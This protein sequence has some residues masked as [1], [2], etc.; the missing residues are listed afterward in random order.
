MG[1][2]RERLK[3]PGAWTFVPA[4]LFAL[5]LVIGAASC[6]SDGGG[7]VIFGVNE[8]DRDV[9]IAVT[10]QQHESLVL[11]ARSQTTLFVSRFN[12][13]GELRVWDA[14]C[15]SLAALPFTTSGISVWVGPSGDV[16]LT[17]GERRPDGVEQVPGA[18][19]GEPALI[20]RN[21]PEVA[22]PPCET[23]QVTPASLSVRH[24]HQRAGALRNSWIPVT[25]AGL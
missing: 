16:R 4:W 7:Y 25:T 8:W 6:S 11:P 17:E 15:N 12:P 21:A 10:G 14:D 13:S 1:R 24:C 18:D 23:W 22:T 20:E 9:V 19:N 5:I 3:W 2:R